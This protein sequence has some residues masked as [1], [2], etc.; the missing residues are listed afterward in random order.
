[1]DTARILAFVERAWDEGVVPALADYIRIPAKSPAYDR[2][3]R[4]HGHLDRAV[5]LV[6]GWCRS[7]Q[8]EGLRVEVH[9]LEGR[10]PVILAEVP[11]A[12]GETV[13]LY[14]H[15]DK[16][17]EMTGWAEGL[18]PWTPVRRGDRLYG[19]GGADDGYAA[20]AALTAL[21]ALQ[22]QGVPHA[23][24]V[25]LIEACE[26]SGSVDLPAHVDALA[27]RLGTPGLVVCLDSG[28]GNYE[29]LWGTTSLRG[30]VNGEL[31]VEVLTEGIHSGASGIVPSSFRVLR[32]V[33]SRLEDEAT[34]AILPRELHAAIPA[35]RLAQARA[36]AAALGDEVWSRFPFVPGMR[37]AAAD[38]VELLLAS[39]WRPALAVTGADGLPA[40]A[41]AGNV[42]R[43][44][45]A[46]KLSLRLPPTL[47]AARAAATLKALLEADPPHGARVTFTP[48][49]LS[50][51]WE[52]PPMREWLAASVDA[53]SRACFGRPAMYQGMGGSIPFMA[54]LGA[55]FP[56]AQFLITGV[57]G[58]ESNAHGPNE[59]LHVPTGVR[60][61]ACV[62][63]VLAD[64][65]RATSA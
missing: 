49:S 64:H 41:D 21:E 33:L 38:P 58:P 43:P 31:A 1:M 14:G 10:T 46:V 23:R 4:A 32:R 30:L 42:L 40:L 54:M 29:Q 50:A 25:V 13:L 59:F 34:G 6:E 60:V 16:Q 57:L 26:E 52:A 62:A 15:V 45:T 12:G 39:T 20:F 3:W 27:G 37:P 22:T 9:R 35:A 44:G 28:C 18:G 17:P 47:D 65:F 56:E 2:E 7:R 53:A 51:G 8:L 11:G 5:A 48:S 63:H 55:R 61:T 19:R 36:V 24:C